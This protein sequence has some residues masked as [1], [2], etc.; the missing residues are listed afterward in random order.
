M[1]LVKDLPTKASTDVGS[2]CQ[3]QFLNFVRE[4]G[5]NYTRQLLVELFDKLLSDVEKPG[6][7]HTRVECRLRFQKRNQMST[8]LCRTVSFAISFKFLRLV[9]SIR[10]IAREGLE[11]QKINWVALY[12]SLSSRPFLIPTGWTPLLRLNTCAPTRT[13]GIPMTLR[14]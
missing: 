13:S 9:S 8:H 6:F 10:K 12:Y 1:A 5:L 7:D 11:N 4:E 14:W 2:L 3:S